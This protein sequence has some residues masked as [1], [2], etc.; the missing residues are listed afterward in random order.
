MAGREAAAQWHWQL[1]VSWAVGVEARRR[2]RRCWQRVGIG[3]SMAIARLQQAVL[4]QRLQRGIGGGS[5][6]AESAE[7]QRQH[8]RGAL[9]ASS[10]AV[11]SVARG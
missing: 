8:S 9:T 6:V 4:Q 1:S 3:S 7:R 10:A 2:R 11:V 5:V